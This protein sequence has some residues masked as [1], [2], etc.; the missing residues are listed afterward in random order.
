M[1]HKYKEVF[2]YKIISYKLQTPSAQRQGA[3]AG[4]CEQG[5]EIL[6][7]L[8]GAQLEKPTE[9]GPLMTTMVHAVSK[10]QRER[11][12]PK[13]SSQIIKSHQKVLIS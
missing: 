1:R 5:N 9:C 8:K 13:I 4:C 10:K 7:S 12:E 2:L 3:V 11:K 6:A